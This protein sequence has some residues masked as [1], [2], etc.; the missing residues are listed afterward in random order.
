[1]GLPTT[2][3]VGGVSTVK[4]GADGKESALLVR[5]GAGRWICLLAA[6][7]VLGVTGAWCMHE[8]RMEHKAEMSRLTKLLI[9]SGERVQTLRRVSDRLD[10]SVESDE[11]KEKLA[12]ELKLGSEVQ[13]AQKEHA[14]A[15]ADVM[16][17]GGAPNV[18][19]AAAADKAAKKVPA[20]MQRKMLDEFR[21]KA[22]F[23]LW[24]TTPERDAAWRRSPHF[25]KAPSSA[26]EE[27]LDTTEELVGEGA[28]STI[29]L[30]SWLRG[31]ITAGNYP[32][33]ADALIGVVGYLDALTDSSEGDNENG[34]FVQYGKIQKSTP[35]NAATK[36][37][38]QRLL[39][40]ADEVERSDV[41]G[42]TT[43]FKSVYAALVQFHLTEWLFPADDPDLDEGE[44]SAFA[45]H[46]LLIRKD[47]EDSYD[48]DSYDY[49]D[50]EG[51]AEEGATDKD[52]V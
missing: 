40:L 49:D 24:S 31:N 37:T 19:H 20:A 18:L 28:I 43:A 13:D 36:A 15:Q 51:E 14:R 5:R 25:G 8:S 9:A 50:E 1:M 52:T 33:P 46:K 4:L 12:K 47:E 44:G 39:T 45:A 32:P 10:D 42:T 26:V 30:V 22:Q 21:A 48:E 29:T 11:L 38:V 16:K 34:L 27:G 35:P 6:V 7:L 41:Q 23:L 2:V 3:D 17:R